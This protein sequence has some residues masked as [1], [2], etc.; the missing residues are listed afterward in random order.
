MLKG[1]SYRTLPLSL[2]PMV[3]LKD[4]HR[5]LTLPFIIVHGAGG[6]VTELTRIMAFGNKFDMDSLTNVTGTVPVNST[7]LQWYT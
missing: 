2:Y 5:P 7:R 6:K 1:G 4:R 3:Q